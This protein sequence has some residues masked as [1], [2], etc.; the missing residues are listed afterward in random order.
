MSDCTLTWASPIQFTPMIPISLSSIF[1]LS[2]HLHLRA[3]QPKP[4]KH[5]SPP[6]LNACHMSHPP[7]LPWSNHL[8]NIRWRIQAVK[9]IVMQFSPRSIFI[10]STSKFPPQYTVLKNP[11]SV[12]LPQSDR[13]TKPRTHTVA[14]TKLQFY[15]F[16]SLDIF[17]WDGVPRTLSLGVKR[18]ESKADHSPPS[19]AEVKEWVELYLHS[20]YMPS[21]RGAQLKQRDNFLPLEVPTAWDNLTRFSR[22]EKGSFASVRKI[23]SN[24]QIRKS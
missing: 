13:P 9:F 22:Q 2:S 12:F 16:Q 14:Q 4:R 7:H 18:P 11:Q 8:N 10:P 15:I 24:C 1:M 21:W 19:S 20:P 5:L 23:N 17:I 3:S 6:L